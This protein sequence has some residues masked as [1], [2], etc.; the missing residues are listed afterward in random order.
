MGAEEEAKAAADGIDRPGE[1]TVTGCP[2]TKE[3]PSADGGGHDE[4]VRQPW[5]D[6]GRKGHENGRR[7]KAGLT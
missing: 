2:E 1:D 6:R 4:S 7:R 5:P 3:P